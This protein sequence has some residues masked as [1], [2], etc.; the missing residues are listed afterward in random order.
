MLL[1]PKIPSG[2]LDQKWDRFRRES[3]LVGPNNKRRYRVLVVGTGLAGASASATLGEL[4]S[5]IHI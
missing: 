1:D 2:P 4:L 5:L 3:S